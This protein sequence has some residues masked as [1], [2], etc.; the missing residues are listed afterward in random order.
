V[1]SE[2]ATNAAQGAADAAR[3]RRFAVLTASVFAFAFVYRFNALGGALGGFD[4]DH[5]LYYLRA[6]AVVHGEL[7]MRDFFDAGLQGAWPA[8]TYELSA[9]FQR[10]TGETL[11][12]EALLSVGAIALTVAII[13]RVSARLTSTWPALAVAL[14]TLFVGAKLYAYPKLLTFAIGVLLL[15]RYVRRPSFGRVASLGA[16]S[17]VAFLFRHDLRVYFAPA[18]AAAIVLGS[19][20]WPVVVTRLAQYALVVTLLLAGP[21]YSVERYVG[22]TTYVRTGLGISQREAERTGIGW[23]GFVATPDR[24]SF[25]AEEQNAAAWLYYLSLTIPAL[26]L[27]QLLLTGAGPQDEDAIGRAFIVS[28][29][30][31]AAMLNWYFL[32]GNLPARFGD[33]GAPVAIL[34]AVL[35]SRGQWRHR[36]GRLAMGTAVVLLSIPTVLAVDTIGSARRE[37]VTT[38]FSEGPVKLAEKA[39]GVVSELRALPPPA[40]GDPSAGTPEMADYLRACT[41]PAD[42]VLMMASAPSLVAMASRSFAGGQPTFTPGFYTSEDDQRRVIERVRAQSVPVVVTS[43]EETYLEDIAPEFPAIHE[44]VMA[45]YEPA[46]TLPARGRDPM[47]LLVRRGLVPVRPYGT[48]GL[49]CFR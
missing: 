28:L 9:L 14:L 34:A 37:L 27:L 16:W 46:G 38:G 30:V 1:S 6:R 23:P 33:L 18:A 35:V 21:L 31:L 36:V 5:F 45:S 7:P 4:D 42:R 43:L 13:F 20:S 3:A 32:R 48:T 10:L 2:V 29:V 8:L 26:V 39:G 44:Y 19:G 41:A 40:M 47:R 49:P 24:L 15:E 11:L 25:F 22:L 17:A 12:G